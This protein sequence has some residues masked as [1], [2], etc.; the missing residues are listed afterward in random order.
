MA[1]GQH[2]LKKPLEIIGT[3]CSQ[4]GNAKEEFD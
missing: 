2:D 4:E 3:L 1:Y